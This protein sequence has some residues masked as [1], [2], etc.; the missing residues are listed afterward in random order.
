MVVCGREWAVEGYS[1]IYSTYS[2]RIPKYTEPTYPWNLVGWTY[3][4]VKY[5]HMYSRVH[6]ALYIYTTVLLTGVG[7]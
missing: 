5:I 2:Y 7:R 6:H 1:S 4:R 3:N